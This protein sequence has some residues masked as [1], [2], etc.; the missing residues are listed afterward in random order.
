MARYYL[1]TAPW[2]YDENM[3]DEQELLFKSEDY[4]DECKGY[5]LFVECDAHYRLPDCSMFVYTDN[6]KKKVIAYQWYFI[7][8]YDYALLEIIPPRDLSDRSFEFMTM[9]RI[10]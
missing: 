7:E 9:L 6:G 10:G 3:T 2:V 5:T 4:T 1:G 8:K